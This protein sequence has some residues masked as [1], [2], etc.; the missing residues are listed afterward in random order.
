MLGGAS[1]QCLYL[2]SLT[3]TAFVTKE[4]KDLQI[5]LGKRMFIP[6]GQT[7]DV[8]TKNVITPS[9]ISFYSCL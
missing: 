1:R 4:E 7:K 5:T 8:R 9:L 6:R 3:G 2:F